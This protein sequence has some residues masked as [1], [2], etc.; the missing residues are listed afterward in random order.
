MVDYTDMDKVAADYM[1]SERLGE[2]LL[3][4]LDTAVEL[5]G[6]SFPRVQV[7]TRKVNL[8]TGEVTEKWETL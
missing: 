6:T 1:H 7:L 3:A 4:G 5:P 2:A 8:V